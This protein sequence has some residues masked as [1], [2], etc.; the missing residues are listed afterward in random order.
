M[1]LREWVSQDE[2]FSFIN[3]PVAHGPYDPP[4]RF[5]EAAG[6]SPSSGDPFVADQN[7][8]AYVAGQLHPSEAAW[9]D[10]RTLYAGGVV[11]ADYLVGRLLE[12]I[13]DDT[14]V[15]LTAD[16]GEHLNEYGLAGHQF[17]LYDELIRVPL[18]ISHPSL[19]SGR[20]N[21]LVSHVDLLPTIINLLDQ[22]NDRIGAV[23][24]PTGVSSKIEPADFYTDL[25][26]LPGRSL[27]NAP[28]PDRTVFAEYG[29][30]AAQMNALRNNVASIDSETFDKLF[31]GIQA[32]VTSEYKLLCYS[33]TT[34]VLYRRNN[35]GK[36]ISADYPDIV[37][38][39]RTVM[40]NSIGSLPIVDESEFSDYVRKEVTNK[41]ES[42][43]YL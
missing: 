39:L 21:D 11:H 43:G 14:W 1:L 28:K 26:D 3:I 9:D 31:R 12:R 20:R 41:L 7:F 33:D 13:P 42:L 5:R 15:I 30:P 24:N 18:I 23:P 27:F 10:L 8:H 6:A 35:E 32:A 2:T 19:D 37:N 29:P 34:E 25:T 38:A 17:S 36:D 22:N 40:N 4:E 16:H